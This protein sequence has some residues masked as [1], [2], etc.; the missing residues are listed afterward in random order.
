MGDI[1]LERIS[2]LS[3]VVFVV[4]AAIAAALFGVWDY[5]PSADRVV[6][7]L[8]E[9]NSGVYA[10]GY[11]G[12]ISAFFLVWFA[13]SLFRVQRAREGGSG[14]LSV[15]ALGGGVVAGATMAIAFSAMVASATR[16]D[17]TAGIS[18]E[19]ALALYDLYGNMAGMAL[20]IGMA[21]LIGASAA[22][23]LKSRLLPAWAAWVSV[24]VVIGLLSP[25]S[26]VFL[27]A[28]LVWIVAVSVWIFW[29]DP[30]TA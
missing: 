3:G 7:N 10:A 14:W 15:T 16:A 5:L 28:D 4:L 18:G 21:L 20:G 26:Y 17:T 13:G 25:F 19:E 24:V 23:W 11:L 30:S 29:K 2:S 22:V 9:N 1:R 8:N 12:V 27:A 6:E